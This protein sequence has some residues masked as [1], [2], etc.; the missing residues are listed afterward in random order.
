MSNDGKM[1]TPSVSFKVTHP[2]WIQTDPIGSP[3]FSRIT[4]LFARRV[5]DN[6]TPFPALRA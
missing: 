1:E 2:D 3:Y 5:A 6:Y 4:D